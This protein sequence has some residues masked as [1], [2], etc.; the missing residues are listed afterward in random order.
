[1]KY[2]ITERQYN[3]IKE[4]DRESG[5]FD[6]EP[7][8]SFFEYMDDQLPKKQK[9]KLFKEIIQRVFQGKNGSCRRGG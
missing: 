6:F 7:L 2:V 8:D 1:M 9:V 3:V 4:I 5:H